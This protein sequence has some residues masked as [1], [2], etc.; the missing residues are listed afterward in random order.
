MQTSRAEFYPLDSY[1][2]RKHLRSTFVVL[3][4]GQEDRPDM[5]LNLTRATPKEH[6]SRY[7][8]PMQLGHIYGGDVRDRAT[9]SSSLQTRLTQNA[10]YQTRSFQDWLIRRLDISPGEKILD[11]GCGTGAQALRFLDLIGDGGSVAA[12]DISKES[13]KALVQSANND[14]RIQAVT[15]DMAT[16]E[17]LLANVFSQKEFTLAHSSYALYYSPQR[18]NVLE[19]MANSLYDFGRLAVFTPTSPHGMVDLASRF[20]PIPDAVYDSLNYPDELQKS[21]RDLFWDVRIDY[22]Q[23]EMRV[24]SLNDF[25]DF[26]RA[27]TY[28]SPEI[29]PQI[30]AYAESEIE[31]SGSICYA[32]NGFLIQGS[33]KR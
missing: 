4:P 8:A 7:H 29:E 24:T 33:S 17:D 9:S 22:F 19:T 31:R 2:V 21:F 25:V 18:A 26:Y 1:A 20:G 12:C 5:P 6:D 14:S 16:L 32:K 30:T 10:R 23:S 3:R 15:A 13:I 11:V 28:Y 27:T